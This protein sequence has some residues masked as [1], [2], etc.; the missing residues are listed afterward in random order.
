MLTLRQRLCK[1]IRWLVLC[2]NVLQ[3]ELAALNDLSDVSVFHIQVLHP[4]VCSSLLHVLDTG[5]AVLHE[6][7]RSA[8]HTQFA[9]EVC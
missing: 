5:Y 3:I 7:K 9:Q 8:N 1:C 2:S 6:N 4:V